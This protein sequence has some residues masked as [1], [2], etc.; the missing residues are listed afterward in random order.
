MAYDLKR[1]EAVTGG[2]T[3]G[4]EVTGLSGDNDDDASRFANFRWEM[5]LLYCASSDLDL[6]VTDFSVV[7]AA[8]AVTDASADADE[9]GVL[10][11]PGAI[12]V[13]I[14]PLGGLISAARAGSL[15]QTAS[16]GI[17]CCRSAS[18]SVT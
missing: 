9:E 15:L 11:R 14:A 5:S 7:A 10:F 8:P 18:T 4:N 1:G 13:I 17:L 2:L 12:I 6:S 16:E 3:K